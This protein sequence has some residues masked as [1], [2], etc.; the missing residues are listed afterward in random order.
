MKLGV[1][2]ALVCSMTILYSCDKSNDDNVITNIE[3]YGM[4][5]QLPEYR[6]V[7]PSVLFPKTIE[8]KKVLNF[9]CIHTTYSLVGTGWQIELNIKYSNDEMILELDRLENITKNLSNL[10]EPDLFRLPVYVTVWNWNG[11]FEYAVVNESEQSIR[12]IYLQL[13][14]KNDLKID[15]SCIPNNYDISMKTNSYSLYE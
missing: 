7:G 4:I 2:L 3:N 8:D 14:D 12:Y 6:I 15:E 9:Q 11:C 10:Q 5:W 13:I 1:C